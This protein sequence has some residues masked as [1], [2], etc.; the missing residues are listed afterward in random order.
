MT[1]GT[2]SV[3]FCLLGLALIFIQAYVSSSLFIRLDN[4]IYLAGSSLLHR[5]FS[6]V[7]SS[8]LF[9]LIILV[10]LGLWWFHL[11]FRIFFFYFCQKNK[12]H[13][14]FDEDSIESIDDFG[15]MDIL[16]ILSL[17]IHE[18]KRLSIYFSLLVHFSTVCL[19]PCYFSFIN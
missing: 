15:S 13:W 18:H 9:F 11:N 7:A 8:A 6:S 2:E 3:T 10:I 14:D 1:S 16:T 4:F 17:L 19:I 12:C 5:L